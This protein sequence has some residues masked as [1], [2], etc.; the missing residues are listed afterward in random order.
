MTFALRT[1]LATAATVAAVAPAAQAATT[2]IATESHAVTVSSYQDAIAFSSYDAAQGSYRLMLDR[3]GTIT[4]AAVAPSKTA[5]DVDLGSARSGTLVAVYSRA[6]RLYEYDVA[7]AKERRVDARVRGAH[8][9]QPTV[10]AGRIAFVARRS[11]HDVLYLR[12][13]DGRARA[14]ASA[15][16]IG[17]PE[18]SGTHLAFVTTRG[19]VETLRVQTLSG[20]ARSVYQARS[21]GINQADIVDPGF[22]ADGK[23]LFWARRNVG[24]GSG[25]RFVRLTLSSG[26]LAYALGTERLYSVSWIDATNGFAMVQTGS[27]DDPSAPGDGVTLITTGAVDFSARP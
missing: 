17:D 25:N 26:R 11:G 14:V 27:D 19:R 20:H 8:V 2:P 9:S 22:D 18:L 21:G 1:L 23:H 6:G 4:P 15:R 3:A 16:S 10:M 24:S 7:A 13:G 12:R 5:F